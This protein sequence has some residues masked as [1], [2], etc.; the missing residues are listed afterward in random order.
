M[1]PRV[2]INFAVL[3]SVSFLITACSKPAPADEAIRAV[4]VITIGQDT[5]RSGAEFA[6][7]VKARIESRLGFRVAG[8]VVR[9]YVEI[10]QKVQAG[11]ILAQLDP[12]DYKLSSDAARAQLSSAT[13]NRD[14]AAADYKRFKDLREQNFISGAELERREANLKAAQAQLDQAQSQATIQGNQATYTTLVAD[15]GGVVTS[16]DAESGQ[17]VSAGVPV[18][19]IAHQGPRDVVIAVPED[20][21][22]FIKNGTV[23]HVRTWTDKTHYPGKVREIAASADPVTRTFMVKIAMDTC[24]LPLGSTVSAA[25][26]LDGQM[27]ASVIKLPM[28]ALHQSGKASAVWMVDADNMTIKLQPVQVATADGN[29]IVIASG[30]QPGMLVVSAGVHV[31]SQGQKVTLYQPKATSVQAASVQNPN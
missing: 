1:P 22:A 8:K 4:K 19:R 12:Q 26:V 3:A 7:E 11:Q 30:L 15:V 9:R 10:G 29:E 13:T 21:V 23:A 16:V 14:L 20:R 2:L 18:V 6:G 27:D 25:L 24:E 5:V 28:S 31:L 17:V